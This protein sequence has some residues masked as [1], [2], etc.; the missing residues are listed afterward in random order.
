VVWFGEM[1]LGLEQIEQAAAE[2]DLFVA[3]GTS[4]LVYPAAAI[5]QWTRPGCRRVEI[6]VEDT[7]QSTTFDEA[8]RGPASL[9]VPEFLQEIQHAAQ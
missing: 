3:I 4:A 5:V 1:P 2:A 7:P 6:N 9:K 8:I